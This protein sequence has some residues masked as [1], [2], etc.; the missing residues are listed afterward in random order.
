MSNV[1]DLDARRLSAGKPVQNDGAALARMRALLDTCSQQLASGDHEAAR[2]QL[3]GAA[4]AMLGPGWEL[5]YS[6]PPG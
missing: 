1:I 3:A 2:M 5:R 6:T 4:L